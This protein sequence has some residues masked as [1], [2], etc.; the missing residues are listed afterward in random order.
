M[1]TIGLIALLLAAYAIAT[2]SDNAEADREE[3][4]RTLQHLRTNGLI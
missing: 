2:A 4:S 1:L 3:E